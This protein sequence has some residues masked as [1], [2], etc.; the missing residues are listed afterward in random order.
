ME[1]N[2]NNYV[3]VTVIKKDLNNYIELC[4]DTFGR[5]FKYENEDV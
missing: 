5:K 2:K 3:G 1:I 4:F